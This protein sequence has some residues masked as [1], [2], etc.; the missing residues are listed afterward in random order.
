MNEITYCA[1]CDESPADTI[2]E[3]ALYGEPVCYGCR[4]DEAAQYQDDYENEYDPGEAQENRDFAQ[5]DM[6]EREP[7]DDWEP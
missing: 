5:D 1:R 6:W 7:L 3:H 4:D 2:V